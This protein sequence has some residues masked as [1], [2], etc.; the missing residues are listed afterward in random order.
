MESNFNMKIIKKSRKLKA[1][2]IKVGSKAS[3]RIKITSEMI[4]TF[5]SLCG[6]YNPLHMDTDY[7]KTTVF[8]KRIS[9][10]IL[11]SSFFSTLIGMYLPGV[12]SLIMSQK[13]EYLK[14]VFIDDEIDIIGIVKKASL[15]NRLFN[16]ELKAIKSNK[17]IVVKA[18]FLVMMRG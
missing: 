7:A 17:I 3:F 12:N 16:M 4:G 2:D 5:A 9:H 1:E 14:P 6:D 13:I 11:V 18:S 8:G 15:N 10:G